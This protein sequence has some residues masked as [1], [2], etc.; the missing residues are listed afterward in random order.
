MSPVLLILVVVGADRLLGGGRPHQL[1]PVARWSLATRPRLI[2][3]V[4]SAPVTYGY[5][6]ILVVTSWVL[7][8]ASGRLGDKLLL[9][10]STTSTSSRTIPCASS[11]VAP[12]GS[13]APAAF[14]SG[15]RS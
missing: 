6:A 7:A 12:S 15:Q 8:S 5:L 14:C 9:A 13:R 4:R 2:A 3:W 1:E 10:Q 11:S